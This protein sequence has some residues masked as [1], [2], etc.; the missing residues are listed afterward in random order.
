MSRV[1]YAGTSCDGIMQSS[2][3]ELLALQPKTTN[4]LLRRVLQVTGVDTQGWCVTHRRHPHS[5]VL[6]DEAEK[7]HPDVLNILLQL[8]DDGHV[9]DSQVH[10]LPKF[11]CKLRLQSHSTRSFRTCVLLIVR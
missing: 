6:F 1:T 9:T 10:L 8:L 2:C 4:R 5:V 11:N 7:A 3:R